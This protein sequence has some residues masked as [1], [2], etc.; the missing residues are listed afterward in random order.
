MKLLLLLFSVF[1]MSVHATAQTSHCRAAIKEDSVQFSGSFVL[2][3]TTAKKKLDNMAAALKNELPCRIAVVA[4]GNDCITCQQTSWDRAYTV[5]QY[6]RQK[7]IDSSRIVFYYGA[8]GMSAQTV[9]IRSLQD[10][11]DGPS[12]VPPPLP[13][14]SRHPLIKRGCS[15]GRQ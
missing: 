1:V 2:L 4:Y 5:A 15:G 11:E 8:D 14:I 6:L 12:A 7:G 9:S 13:C 10:G 3:S